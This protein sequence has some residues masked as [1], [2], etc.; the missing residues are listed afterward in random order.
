MRVKVYRN[1]DRPFSLFGIRGRFIALAG[2]LALCI[3]IIALAGALAL[4]IIIISL[5]VGS[6]A[7]P[8]TGLVTAAVL[9]AAGY[10]SVAEVQQRFGMKSLG[11]WTS[12]LSLPE[13]IIIRNKVWRRSM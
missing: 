1:L 10:V 11:R 4:C 9:L 13:Y 6:V 8:V 7:G 5:V 12:G 3:I 2:A